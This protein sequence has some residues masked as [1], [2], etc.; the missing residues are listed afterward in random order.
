MVHTQSLPI[1]LLDLIVS[2]VRPDDELPSRDRRMKDDI[3]TLRN[4]CLVSRKFYALGQ[5]LLFRVLFYD[6]SHDYRM[7]TRTICRRPDLAKH[8]HQIC[9]LP[10]LSFGTHLLDAEDLELSKGIIEDLQLGDQEDTWISSIE[11]ADLGLFTALVASKAPNLR[12]LHLPVSQFWIQPF[13]QLFRH[14]PEF[15]SNLESIW[16]ESDEEYCNTEMYSRMNIA[17]YEKF[18]TLPKVKS[19]T[20]EYGVLCDAYLRPFPSSWLPGTLETER[21]AFHHCQVDPFALEKLMQACKKLKAF[22]YNNF[23]LHPNN[24]RNRAEKLPEFNAKQAYEAVLL[25]KDTLE[26]FHLEYGTKPPHIDIFEQVLSGRVQVGSFRDFS[27][28]ETIVITHA[29][30][31]PHPEFPSSLKTLHIMN[32][33]ASVWELTQS[34]A[35][36]CENGLYPEL[37][38]VSVFAT[39]ITKPAKLQGKPL[40]QCLLDLEEM[41]KGTKVNFQISPYEIPYSDD[42]DNLDLY[43][44]YTA[45]E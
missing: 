9:I 26:L 24:R 4:V 14:N 19:S 8:V 39:D 15:L 34:I 16:I 41:F 11:G 17:S 5:P 35:K 6:G 29:F 28:L 30:L 18:L 33:K 45:Q 3:E 13:I 7:F 43:R 1:E 40:Q 10:T 27:V 31:P 38:D 2:F 25:H 21:L 20:F 44:S 32:C 42:Y 12:W 36:D 23:S 37:T 22:T